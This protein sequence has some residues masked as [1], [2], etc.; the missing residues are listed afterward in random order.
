MLTKFIDKEFAY[1]GTQLRS[2]FAY[3]DHGLLGDSIVAWVGPCNIDFTHMVDGEDLL[4]KAEIRGSRMVHFIVE[5]FQATLPEMVALQRLLAAIVKDVV[6]AKISSQ[7]TDAG[8][9]PAAAGAV[10][11]GVPR[12][13]VRRDGDD[14][15]VTL[16]SGEGKLSISI[17]TVSPSSGL[18]H[19][20]VNV[21]NEGTPVKTAS[22]E[23]LRFAAREFADL[24]LAAFAHECA[25][26]KD[27]TMKVKWVK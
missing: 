3:L 11:S 8:A 18:V 5:K 2:L 27:A 21:S 19:F 24:V 6:V 15:Y 25:S 14:V 1:D 4:A 23:D 26:I 20:A 7:S 17:A 13:P 10:A 12:F 9:G 22:L 16:P